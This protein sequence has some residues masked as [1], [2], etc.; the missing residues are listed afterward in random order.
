MNGRSPRERVEIQR[1]RR[2]ADLVERPPRPGD[3]GVVFGLDDA[4]RRAA[5][6]DDPEEAAPVEQG[7]EREAYR[8]I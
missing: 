6:V 3:E 1:H 2:R 7:D 8:S 4:R 5:V